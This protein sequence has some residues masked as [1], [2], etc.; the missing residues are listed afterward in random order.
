MDTPEPSAPPP[1]GP[2]G[3]LRHPWLRLVLP[4][5]LT[6][7]AAVAI[8]LAVQAALVRPPAPGAAPPTAAP[9][10]ANPTQPPEPTRTPAP[11]LAE[12]ISRQELADVRAEIDR[13]WAAI[14][15]ARAISQVS[16]AETAL[17]AN[18]LASVEQS[19][20]SVDAV[21]ALA[22]RRASGP[23]KDPINQFRRDIGEM[24][25]DLYLRPEGMDRRLLD[26]RQ[27]IL[28]LIEEG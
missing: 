3:A 21:L 25:G 6:A 1:S 4:H 11:P 18:D 9:A 16:D 14:Y 28:A 24:Y 17:R 7:V 20:I 8:S 15:L 19:L 5:A 26:L 10:T 12:G 27:R 23:V 22:I 13:L 2:T